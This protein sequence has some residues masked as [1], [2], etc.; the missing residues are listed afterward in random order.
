[1]IYFLMA[2]VFIVGYIAIALEH[3]LHV[4]KAASALLTAIIIWTLLVFG[5]DTLLVARTG[6]T[7]DAHAI[8]ELLNSELRHH[9]AEIAEI[10][11]F[12]MGAMVIVEL[13]DAHH[14]FDTI[15]NRIQTSHATTLLW[16][17]GILTFFL[18]ALL[19]NLTTTIVMISLLRK[20]VADKELRWWFAGIIVVC[21]NAG[22]A[23]SPIGDVTTT[24]LWIGNQITAHQIITSLILPSLIAAI[25]PIIALTFIIKGKQIQRP[26]GSNASPLAVKNNPLDDFLD[27]PL[28]K[29]Q[30]SGDMLT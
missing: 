7:S 21:A 26:E 16:I 12:L 11:F 6:N 17:I 29:P 4:D 9:L 25:L 13:I 28:D 27:N 20:L 19:D 18:S 22:G 23:W 10:L 15:T 8:T 24:M 2:A 30:Q 14:G 5:A 1:M 3:N